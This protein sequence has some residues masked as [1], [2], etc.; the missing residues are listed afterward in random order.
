MWAFLDGGNRLM[1]RQL[2]TA[3]YGA[4][5]KA[6]VYGKLRSG[7]N[8]KVLMEVFPRALGCWNLGD[9]KKRGL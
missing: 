5:I 2:P 8:A 4:G 9:P 3:E 7:Q 1:E 6:F